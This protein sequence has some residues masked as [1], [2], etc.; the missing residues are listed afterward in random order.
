VA[1]QP[2]IMAQAVGKRFGT[3]HALAG[4]D[5]EVPAGGVVGLL[6]PNGAGKTTLVRILATLLRPDTGRVWVAGLDVVR[7]AAAVRRVIGLSGQ[8]AAVDGY[9]TGREN[10]RMIGRLSGLGPAAARRRA[11]ELLERFDLTDGAGRLVRTYSGGMRRRLCVAASLV[12]APRVLFLDEPTTGLDPRGRIGLW[13]LLGELTAGGTSVL[14]TTQYLEE[15]DRL[16]ERIVVLDAGRVVATG[17]AA[18][19]KARVGGDRLELEV[20]PGDD[21]APLAAALAGLGSG[22]PVVDTQ[23]GRLILPVAAGPAILPEVAAR[24]AAADLHI[25]DLAL[26]RPTLDDVFLTLTGQPMARSPATSRPDLE[27]PRRGD[28][29]TAST[30]RTS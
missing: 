29:D 21:P 14:L 6:G 19:L 27:Q 26:R 25:T 22:K 15:A 11:G 20:P 30:T 8:Y 10:L 24:L 13:T 18:Q 17:T 7:Q 5:L 23:T 12:A 28:T 1:D 4:V 9:L 16:T 2:V 3:V